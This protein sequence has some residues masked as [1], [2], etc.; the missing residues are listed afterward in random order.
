MHT[1]LLTTGEAARILNLSVGGVRWLIDTGRLK[2]VRTAGGLRLLQADDVT[3]LAQERQAQ[4]TR[5][6]KAS[7]PLPG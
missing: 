4:P 3:R 2:A 5:R 7:M 1:R 6:A